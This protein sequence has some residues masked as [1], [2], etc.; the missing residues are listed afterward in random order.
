MRLVLEVV[1]GPLAGER[2]AAEESQVVRIGRAPNSD[3][4]LADSFLSGEHFAVE[5][6][7]QGCRLRDLNSRNG[8]K[9]NGEMITEAAL[10]HGDRIYAGRTDFIVRIENP[11]KGVVVPEQVA[12]SPKPADPV[13]V[14]QKPSSSREQAR[15][16]SAKPVALE[17]PPREG[18]P[19]D[20][21]S[22]K[23]T[24]EP[25]PASDIAKASSASKVPEVKQSAPAPVVTPKHQ[26]PPALERAQ[27]EKKP[28]PPIQSKPHP[29]PSTVIPADA[30][31]SYEAA[32][33][34]GRLLHILSSQSQTLMALIDATHDARVLELLRGAREESQSLYRG[35]QN[36]A[37]APYLV[38]L[39]PRSELLKQM[40]QK[41]WGHEWGVY[42]TC[43]LPLAE[44]RAYFRTSLMVTMPDGMELFSRFYDPAFFRV[45]LETCTAEEAEKFFGPVTSY[46][47]EGDRPEITLQFTRSNTG[48]EKRGH[49]L[50][51]LT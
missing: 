30:L 29:A 7:L 45:F 50:S 40:I 16:P 9:L 28:A 51:V 3:V 19:A 47:M 17:L 34:D 4:A 5:C 49:L 13:A 10:N 31:N 41:G 15:K 2:I 25:P 12:E 48:A 20:K 36:A 32:T 14:A 46:F 22:S 8:T 33:P 18:S 23:S 21:T 37:I 6:G 26:P 27:L 42:L 44:L 35:E 24:K 1:S 11:P 43:A 39:P 38:H